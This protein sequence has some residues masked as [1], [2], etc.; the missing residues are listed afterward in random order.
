MKHNRL[1]YYLREGISSVF[2][3]GFMSVASVCVIV[4]CLLMMGSFSLLALNVSSIISSMEDEN[5]ILVYIDETYTNQQSR[6]VQP[7]IEAVPN[8]ASATFI[9]REQAFQSFREQYEDSSLLDDLDA[10]ILRDRYIVLLDDI[11]YMA[12]TQQ[13]LRN[14]DGVVKV[15]AHL[16]LSKGFI[17]LRNIVS[18]VSVVIVAVLF[19]VSLFIMSNTIKLTTFERREEIAI[20][21][22][23]GATSSFIR[24]PFVIEGLILGIFAACIGFLAQWGIY[25]GIT[26]AFVENSG[27]SFLK[28]IP[29][30]EVALPLLIVFAAVGVIVGAIGS[31]LAIRNYLKV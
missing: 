29:F 26:K 9:S 1:G 19:V 3:H 24:W 11:S 25:E 30:G 7:A 21:K 31:S 27:L 14:I 23:V 4:A 15:S 13:N 8:V 6:S 17:T 2:D 16:E 20:M 12:D 5:Q 28:V 10:S 22:M 18:A